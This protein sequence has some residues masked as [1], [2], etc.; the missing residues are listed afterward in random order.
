MVTTTFKKRTITRRQVLDALH[1]FAEAHPD[2]NTFDQ[3]LEK[4]SYRYAVVY[5]DRR[6]P[7]K[8]I[9]SAVSGVPITEFSGGEETNRVFRQLGFVVLPK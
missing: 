1:T 2:S 4:E 7:P 8:H 9:L 5:R 6:Y 3:W